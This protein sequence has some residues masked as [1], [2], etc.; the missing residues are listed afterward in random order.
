MHYGRFERDVIKR[1]ATAFDQLSEPTVDWLLKDGGLVDLRET[2]VESLILPTVGYGLKEIC[3]HKELVRDGRA[4]VAA[5][6]STI[7]YP[8]LAD[9]P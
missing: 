9:N 3:K 7:D 1:Y 6:Q 2:V 4:V 5:I 8:D